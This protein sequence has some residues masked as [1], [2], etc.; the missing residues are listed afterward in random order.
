[1]ISSLDQMVEKVLSLR[2]KHVIAVAWAQD[3]NTV[4]AVRRA[5]TD[6]FAEAIMVGD[7]AAV[8]AVC[9]SENIDPSVFRIHPA[10]NESDAAREAVRLT[11][12]G[13]ADIVMKGLVGT[14][15]FLKA[16]MDKESGLMLPGAVLSYVGAVQIPAYH[17]LLFI[18]D[19]AVIPFPDLQ[20]K[21]AMAGYA[22]KMARRFGIEKPKVALISA[23]E[24]VSRHFPNTAEY[25]EMCR[26]AEQGLIPDC[27]MDGP[28]DL[29]LACDRKS[30]EIKGINTPVGGDADIL[31]FPSLEA[32]NPFYKS[33]MLFAGGELAGLI[34]GTA[35]PVV[36]MSR[37]ES[38]RSKYYCI[39]LSCLMAET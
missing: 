14:D 1:M 6:G 17:K 19:T 32:C 9:R 26:M 18:T 24:K 23:T 30:V 34:T 16:V 37:S 11:V 29:F 7:P 28:L 20:Q 38:E 12:S 4:G 25:V 10:D 21:I 2:R 22:V 35:K 33:L 13:E 8:K 27:I 36:V 31:L 39:A 3:P 15:K 5:V